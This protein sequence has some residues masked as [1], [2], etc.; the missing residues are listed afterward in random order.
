M[1]GKQRKRCTVKE[2]KKNYRVREGNIKKR[3]I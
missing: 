2:N 1:K 3:I